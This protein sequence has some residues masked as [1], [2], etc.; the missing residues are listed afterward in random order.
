MSCAN[1]LIE[2]VFSIPLKDIAYIAAFIG[3]QAKKHRRSSVFCSDVSQ[4][5]TDG[6]KDYERLRTRRA[7]L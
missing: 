3:K 1:G 5:I 6:R 2:N 4:G 7:S